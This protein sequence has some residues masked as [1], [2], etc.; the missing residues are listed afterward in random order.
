ML[1]HS[2]TVC[3]TAVFL[4]PIAATLILTHAC[5]AAAVVAVTVAPAVVDMDDNGNNG[6]DKRQLVT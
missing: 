4:L 6:S 1:P 5:P 2:R 3:A